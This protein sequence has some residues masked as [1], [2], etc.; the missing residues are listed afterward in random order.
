MMKYLFI[1]NQENLKLAE[2]EV[3]SLLAPKEFKRSAQFLV[4]DKIN[5]KLIKRLAYTKNVYKILFET[6]TI[7]KDIKKF[8]WQKYYKT[9]FLVRCSE[10]EKERKYASL[11]WHIL[12]KP[13][14]NLSSPK[15]IFS[16]I[17]NESITYAC[18]PVW[19]NDH[20]F[21][22]RR[23]H[24]RPGHAGT[25]M[26]PK[27]A[28]AAINLTGIKKGKLVDLFCGSGGILLE[29]GL[30]GLKPIGYDIDELSIEK[31]KKNLKH[32]K[33]K[34]FILYEKDSLKTNKKLNYLATDLPYGQSSKLSK[35]LNLLYKQFFEF[36]KNNLKKNAVVIVKENT[37]YKKFIKH[38]K[39]KM[40]KQR[41]HKNMTKVI[42]LIESTL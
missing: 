23:S 9:S 2:Q 30:I 36:L 20:K 7:E 10:T 21:E 1:L 12:E 28:R 4:V 5:E 22:E 14:V 27:L 19:E 37:G 42:I 34:N 11:I 39:T 15:T 3:V 16:F 32:Y 17:K 41:I 38:F 24:L 40:F 25:S 8:N 31:A 35:E 33:V 6:K 13:K 18:Q 26:H 29:A